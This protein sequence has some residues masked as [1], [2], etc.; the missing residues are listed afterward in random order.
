LLK[1][2]REIQEEKVRLQWIDDYNLSGAGDEPDGGTNFLHGS[3]ELRF[4]TR[5]DRD[6]LNPLRR[7]GFVR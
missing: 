7:Y 1:R 5:E 3:G 2:K 4:E 6:S